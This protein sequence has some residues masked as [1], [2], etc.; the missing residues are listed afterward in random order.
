MLEISTTQKWV[1]QNMLRALYSHKIQYVLKRNN[2]SFQTCPFKETRT[3]KFEHLSYLFEKRD[4]G[5]KRHLLWYRLSAT[6]REAVLFR[7][8]ILGSVHKLMDIFVDLNMLPP[9]PAAGGK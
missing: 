6:W 3:F 7:V 8:F 2:F 9:S 5:G 4:P 1:N